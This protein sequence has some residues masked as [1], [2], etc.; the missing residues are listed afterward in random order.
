[1]LVSI[2]I[3]KLKLLQYFPISPD[4]LACLLILLIIFFSPTFSYFPIEAEFLNKLLGQLPQEK[5]QQRIKYI[6][7]LFSYLGTFNFILI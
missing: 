3:S 2:Q 1:M 6:I 7:V 4:P 5:Q